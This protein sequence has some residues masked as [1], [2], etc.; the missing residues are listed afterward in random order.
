M[1]PEDVFAVDPNI[2]WVGMATSKGK[3]IFC[4]MRHGVESLTPEEDLRALLELRAQFMS[5]M[6]RTVSMWAGS[7]NYVAINYEKF[8]EL[9]VILKDEYV[10]VTLEKGTPA[11]SFDKITESIRA[12]ESVITTGP[13]A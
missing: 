10:V 3:V 12:M 7:T 11:A 2:R 6:C 13:S 5:D 4:E 8:T 1:T 9:I